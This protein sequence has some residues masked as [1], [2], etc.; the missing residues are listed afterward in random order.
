MQLYNAF[1][2]VAVNPTPIPCEIFDAHWL[3]WWNGS[4]LVKGMRL[5][6]LDGYARD[7]AIK[8]WHDQPRE[9][10]DS[11]VIRCRNGNSM[12][13]RLFR[14]IPIFSEAGRIFMALTNSN[15][16]SAP[17]FNLDTD[18]NI[19]G[20]V[21][22]KGSALANT[23]KAYAYNGSRLTC[24]QSYTFTQVTLGQTS[25]GAA[26]AGNRYGKITIN[27]GTTGTWLGAS[28]QILSGISVAPTTA[29]A[30]SKDCEVIIVGTSDSH[31]V[32]V[33][34]TLSNSGGV[35]KYSIYAT[36]GKVLIQYLD[37]SWYGGTIAIYC[38]V[39]TARAN[40][41]PVINNVWF[42]LSVGSINFIQGQGAQI[43]LNCD[44]RANS[45]ECSTNV[46]KTFY[47]SAG[48]YPL[49]SGGVIDVSAWAAL[50][51][52]AGT[53][54]SSPW[55]IFNSGGIF[56]GTCRVAF[57]DIRPESGKLVSEFNNNFN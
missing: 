11:A 54:T 23:D 37:T 22:L 5:F 33:N 9:R 17:N 21:A 1:G 3:E 12:Q 44:F 20:L 43:A 14:K 56:V 24:E 38:P 29:D 7:I 19:A 2:Q 4:T 35:N 6:G 13:T 49:A 28:N 39:D 31:A 57:A 15:S 55:T 47:L 30:S 27:A 52:A 25:A 18:T 26:G 16:Y 46:S 51:A 32:M 8:H 50:N 34:S 53:S 40:V 48:N 42:D 41:A 36:Y 10:W 45:Y